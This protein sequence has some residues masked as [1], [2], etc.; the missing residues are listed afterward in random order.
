MHTSVESLNRDSILMP[1]P[2]AS[3]G[4]YR[5]NKSPNESHRRD[6]KPPFNSQRSSNRM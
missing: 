3:P 6:S 5:P 1:P 2:V 4:L